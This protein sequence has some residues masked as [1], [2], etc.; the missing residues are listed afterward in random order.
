[1]LCE[2]WNK[3]LDYSVAPV[4]L[5]VM[6]VEW[7]DKGT[8]AMAESQR[9]EACQMDVM[10]Q[11]QERSEGQ[12]SATANVRRL[13]LEP[14][15]AACV[16]EWERLK[17]RH[18]HISTSRKAASAR[19][20]SLARFL[21]GFRG[22]LE[23]GRPRRERLT[24]HWK[25]DPA[26]NFSRMRLRL[27]PHIHFSRHEAASLARDTSNSVT[28]SALRLPDAGTH[29]KNRTSFP[30]HVTLCTSQRV[31]VWYG[32][33]FLFF[34]VHVWVSYCPHYFFT[35]SARRESVSKMTKATSAAR[36]RELKRFTFMEQPDH[37][38]HERAQVRPQFSG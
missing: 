11:L 14:M 12:Q 29:T 16:K 38:E 20:L 32:F 9:Q 36:E 37:I 8:L 22:F 6:D 15:D 7:V 25:L 13:I 33:S 19:W 5:T 2:T 24:H 30:D 35:V 28:P 23:D 17:T 18:S 34:F 3:M 26:E 31:W 21:L 1:M 4:A 27:A 10:E